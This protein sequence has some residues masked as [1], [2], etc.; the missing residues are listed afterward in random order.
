MLRAAGSPAVSVGLVADPQYA[1][2]APAGTRFYRQSIA[3]LTEAVRFFDGEEL[4]F[5]VNLG[6]IINGDWQS[7]DRILEPLAKSR[8]RVHHVLGNHDFEVADEFKPRV[9]GRLGL[10]RRYYSVPEGGFCFVMMDTND[11]SLYA[12]PADSKEHAAA[13]VELQLLKA[14]R[15]ANAQTWNGGVGEAQLQW[16]E[17]T[18]RTAAKAKQKVIVFAHHPIFPA[19]AHTVWNSNAVLKVVERNRNA[20]AWING[21]NHD[22]AFGSYQGVPCV[23]LKG[24]V[25]KADTNAFATARIYSD[26]LELTGHG[27]ETSRELSF[28]AES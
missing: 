27:S 26:H 1:D 15:A 23:T 3:K 16:L 11:V 13:N 18:C 24:M 9:P 21:H 5:C 25:E 22:G 20:V 10:E 19:T 2:I 6:D 8:H 28:R 14:A 12:Y 17:E 4:A 7:F